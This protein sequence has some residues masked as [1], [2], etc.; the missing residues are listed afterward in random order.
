MTSETLEPATTRSTAQ[1][2]AVLS[3]V[4]GALAVPLQVGAWVVNGTRFDGPAFAAPAYYSIGGLLAQLVM[5]GAI[6]TA[7][8]ALVRSR[9]RGLAI[10]GLTLGVAALAG[11]PLLVH[12]LL[13]GV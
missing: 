11:L 6:A 9:G 13:R 2:L 5:A 7:V 10:V 4:L 12:F 3:V 1:R 8:A